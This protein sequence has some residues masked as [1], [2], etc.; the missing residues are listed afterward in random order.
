[1][2]AQ[3]LQGGR[4]EPLRRRVQ[5]ACGSGHE[6]GGQLRD[7]LAALAQRRQLQAHHVEAMQQVGTEFSLR[8]QAFQI[9]MGGGDHAHIDADQ[10]ASTYA[11]EFALGE[12]TQQARL[13]RQRHVADFIKEQGAAVGLLEATDVAPL[14]TGERTRFVAEQ[15]AFQQFGGNRGGVQRDERMLR[16]WRFA[17]QRIGHQLLA[18]TGLADDQHRQ[19]RLREAA[20]GAEQRAHRWRVAHQ[21]RRLVAGCVCGGSG[22]SQGRLHCRQHALGQRYR[23]IQVEWLGQELMRAAAERTGGTG[24]IGVGRHHH[25]RQ[26]RQRGLQLVQQHQTI[27]AGH[28]HVGEQ[29]RRRRAFGQRFQ[30]GCRAVEVEHL[31]AGLAQRG[32]QHEAHGAVIVDDPDARRGRGRLRHRAGP[33]RRQR[34]RCRSAAAG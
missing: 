6:R 23:I 33:P 14:R 12:H 8:D 26:L 31:V 24:D 34:C 1:M 9:L 27:V 2:L 19:R 22:R 32:A 10:F 4:S 17:V 29:Q 18:G 7:V 20:D 25:H 30:R 16:T 11:E 15:L 13:Q 3:C 5:L 21:L 28:A